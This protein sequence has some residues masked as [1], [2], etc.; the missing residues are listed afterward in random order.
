MPQVLDQPLLDTP[1]V[2]GPLNDKSIKLAGMD[3]Q[4]LDIAT[5]NT[6]MYDKPMLMQ[7]EA[8]TIIV[9]FA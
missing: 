7:A 4:E 6:L 9:P 3:G 2:D 1:L 5:I 8:S